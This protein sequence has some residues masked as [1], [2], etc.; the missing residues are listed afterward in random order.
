MNRR[1]EVRWAEIKKSQDAA[2]HQVSVDTD[3]KLA[4]VVAK[5]D[6]Q[7]HELQQKL[8]AGS[9]TRADSEFEFVG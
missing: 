4:A 1:S 6:V 3:A 7:M 5:I 2:I 9:S 8:S